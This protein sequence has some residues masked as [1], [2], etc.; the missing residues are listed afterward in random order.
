MSWL[1]CIVTAKL[2]SCMVM[3]GARLRRKMEEV[4]WSGRGFGESSSSSF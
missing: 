4:L 2:T 1:T 3:V